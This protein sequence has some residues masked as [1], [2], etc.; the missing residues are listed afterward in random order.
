MAASTAL[1]VSSVTNSSGSNTIS[2][3]SINSTSGALT[4]TT[5]AP[6]GTGPV[7]MSVMRIAL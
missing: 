1:R 4:A 7:T 6:T 3:Y 5:T 2:V